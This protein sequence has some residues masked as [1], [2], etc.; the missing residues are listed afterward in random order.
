[1]GAEIETLEYALGVG[2]ENF[3]R[4]LAVEQGEYDRDQTAHDQRVTVADE[5]EMGPAG[6]TDATGGQPHLAGAPAHTILLGA[7][8]LGERG[9]LPSEIDDVAVTLLPIVEQREVGN[10]LVNGHRFASDI[11]A[12]RRHRKPRG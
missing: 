3:A 9:Q 11:C 1:M 8:R 4:R 2:G 5:V 10:D 6:I 12:R 7:F